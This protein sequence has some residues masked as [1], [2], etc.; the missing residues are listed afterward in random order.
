MLIAVKS[1]AAVVIVVIVVIAIA[2]AVVVTA[3][4]AS[5]WCGHQ[6]LPRMYYAEAL[7]QVK[8]MCNCDLYTV[9]M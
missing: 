1:G 7:V 2:A 9:I 4:A 8:S 6:R 3:V 5:R